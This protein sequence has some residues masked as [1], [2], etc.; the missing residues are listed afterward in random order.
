MNALCYLGE[1]ALAHTPGFAGRD[2]ASLANCN[3][4][5][6]ALCA[7]PQITLHRE[8]FLAA[9]NYH[10]EALQLDVARQ[11]PACGRRRQPC[12]F[13]VGKMQ[14]DI[15]HEKLKRFFKRFWLP[16]G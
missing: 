9:A 13:L 1:E 7:G 16:G 4:D 14:S 11:I 6:L 8:R 2:V 3:T 5:R 10:E 15:G 12:D